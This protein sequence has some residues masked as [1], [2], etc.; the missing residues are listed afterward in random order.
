MIK[1]DFWPWPP[2]WKMV[3]ARLTQSKSWDSFYHHTEG[4]RLSWPQV[5]H[6]YVWVVR[7]NRATNFRGSNFGPQKF[8]IIML[9]I[10][11]TFCANTD[12][13]TGIRCILRAHN[14][15]KCNCGRGFAPDPAGELTVLP[16]PLSYFQGAALWW[17]GEGKRWRERKECRKWWEGEG[18]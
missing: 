12:I 4:R 16:R 15:A 9:P 13:N 7:P 14:A 11:M 8:R 18:R 3:P 2:C 10:W 17:E 5:S 1:L 6:R